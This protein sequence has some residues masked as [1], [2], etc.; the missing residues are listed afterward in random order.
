MA[1]AQAAARPRAGAIAIFGA[2]GDLAMRMVWPS[3]FH[4]HREGRLPED[5]TLV[6][7]ARLALSEEE[8]RTK[9]RGEIAQRV[10]ADAVTGADW[11]S[12][13][14]RLRYLAIDATD[15]AQLAPLA[16]LAPKDAASVMYLAVSPALFGRIAAALGAAGLVGPDTRLA[17]EKPIGGDRESARAINA[18]V[19]LHFHERQVFRVDHYL[20]KEAVQNLLAL[21]FGNALFEPIWNRQWIDH[22]QIA[23]A[24]TIGV[25][26]RTDYYD[27]YGAL[28]DMAQNHLLQLLCLTAMEPPYSLDEEAV[29]DEK[30]KV[31][32]AL[33]P[34]PPEHIAALSV[35][36]QYGAGYIGGALAPSYVEEAKG[37]SATETYVALKAEID[38][39]RWSGV[40]FYVRT[41]K[42]LGDRRTYI[43]V[44]FRAVPH[45]I[46]GGA[47]LSNNELV[48]E[49]QPDEAIALRLMNKSPGIGHDGM[50]LRPLSL[51][52]SLSDSFKDARRRIAYERL[53]LDMIDGRT[54]LFVRSDEVDASWAW[55][56]QISAAWKAADM[57][58]ETYPAGSWG[59][60]GAKA[61]IARD[62]RAWR[63]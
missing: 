5:A 31:L 6:G 3:L 7:C 17:L 36:G 16:A 8:F 61:L 48:I 60:A 21:R 18:Q 52:L 37:P 10:G 47:A 24:E 14:Q 55:I 34:F 29:R 32:R 51:D 45:S 56:D 50:T 9:A 4:L 2:T 59:P 40:P 22:V 39:W 63:D 26:G 41:G 20:G 49:L 35:R 30:V 42:R 62:G 15:P 43:V 12:F 58:C 11:R 1:L 33:K 53:F 57:P 13:A 27:A 44:S 54:T 19:A 25:E 28:R 23:I 46:F 38:N